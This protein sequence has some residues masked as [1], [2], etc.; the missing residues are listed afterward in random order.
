MKLIKLLLVLIFLLPRIVFADPSYPD[1]CLFQFETEEYAET[2]KRLIAVKNHK[3]DNLIINLY[4][5]PIWSR[6]YPHSEG[7]E[8]EDGKIFIY[9]SKTQKPLFHK[10][11]N[12][13]LFELHSDG[14]KFDKY[15]SMF[16]QTNNVDFI[17]KHY[18]TGTNGDHNVLF[19]RAKPEFLFLGS[20]F[21]SS[22]KYG[23]TP[24]FKEYSPLQK[25][26][27]EYLEW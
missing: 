9:D 22:A 27:K 2:R 20:L 11:T 19:F 1:E 24:K 15:N 21:Y 6:M 14:N 25:L 3:I 17:I 13:V 7:C 12:A 8:D 4:G 16:S 18:Y 5:T 26:I 23:G 10:S